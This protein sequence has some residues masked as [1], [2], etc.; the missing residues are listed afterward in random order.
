M[1]IKHFFKWF[2]TNFSDSVRIISKN[3][4]INNG[5]ENSEPI[6]ILG[7]D[8]NAIFHPASQKVYKYGSYAPK[9]P[10]NYKRLLTNHEKPN[11]DTKK[12]SQ[13]HKYN[14]FKNQQVFKEVCKTIDTLVSQVNPQKRLLLCVDGVAGL[15]KMC[16][17]RQRRFRSSKE[18]SDL[19]C[20][21]DSCSITPGTRFMNDMTQYIRTYIN[22][23]R[24][25]DTYW[26]SLEVV[27]SDE[28][29]PGE[30]EHTIVTYIRQ[31]CDPSESVCINGM[32][33]DLIMLGIIL[34][35]KSM[36]ILRD[37]PFRK[38]IKYVIHLSNVAS[39]LETPKYMNQRDCVLDFVFLCY[40]AGNDFL[41]QLPSIE[42]M[43]NG[44]DILL[45]V[46]RTIC[47]PSRY[48]VDLET[49]VMNIDTVLEY[50]KMLSKHEIP[51]LCSKYKKRRMYF[52]DPLL[53]THFRISQEH[54]RLSRAS[55]DTTVV[56]CNF[57]AYRHDYYQKHFD[58]NLE[59]GNTESDIV[60]TVCNEYLK[61]LQWVIQ[62]YKL[63]IPTWTWCYPY[64]Y[65]PL[66]T[67]L[68]DSK[69]Q[70]EPFIP[71]DPYP[72]LLQLLCV[73]PPQSGHLIPYPLNQIL[74]HP[75]SPMKEY[76]PSDFEV[77]KDGKRYEWEAIVLLPMMNVELLEKYY[78]KFLSTTDASVTAN[79]NQIHRV[80]I[81]PSI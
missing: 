59:V 81:Y 56:E 41:P 26:K 50:F 43:N 62:Y 45:E 23:K 54:E 47:T 1:G 29:V 70:H 6:D 5:T 80:E 19:N 20:E 13:R 12:S 21:F 24:E 22:T 44:I 39:V 28:Q 53:E 11:R 68:C 73:L 63:G 64:H 16:Q 48:L 9:Q 52:P 42:I 33:A 76:Y 60:S 32:D 72:P 51:A 27:F 15:A 36:Y 8:L 14:A 79:R 55:R 57:D 35:R 74:V 10:Q 34:N 78:H 67:D 37:D 38:D 2:K 71:S 61:G 58:S 46:Y 17:Q 25:K 7:L 75:N 65:G 18:L 4:P 66:I 31:N 3:A 49:C 77:D 40:M 69:Y 30:G